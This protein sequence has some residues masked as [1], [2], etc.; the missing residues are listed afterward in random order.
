MIRS[1]MKVVM[2]PLLRRSRWLLEGTMRAG[3]LQGIRRDLLLGGLSLVLLEA[4]RSRE[5]VKRGR[6]LQVV[7]DHP[8]VSVWGMH[9]ISN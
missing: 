8:V 5:S 6:E 3:S 1:T 2:V 7:Y 9:G 4:S